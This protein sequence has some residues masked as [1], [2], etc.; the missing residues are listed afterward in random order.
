MRLLRRGCHN[1]VGDAPDGD[2]G[3]TTHREETRRGKDHESEYKGVFRQILSLLVGPQALVYPETLCHIVR[4]PILPP[5]RICPVPA[6]PQFE[7][8]PLTG[9]F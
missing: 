1:I 5:S 9:N 8:L 6:E 7:R 4:N 3:R 2:D